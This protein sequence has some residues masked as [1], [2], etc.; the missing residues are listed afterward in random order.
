MES[1]PTKRMRDGL[2]HNMEKRLIEASQE[3]LVE[4]VKVLIRAGVD[5]NVDD[6]NKSLFYAS[7]VSCFSSPASIFIRSSCSLKYFWSKST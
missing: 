7:K 2:K 3:G 1:P 6:Y 4:E 5:V